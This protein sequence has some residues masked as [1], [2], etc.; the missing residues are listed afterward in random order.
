MP[1][2]E[3]EIPVDDLPAVNMQANNSAPGHGW[4][5]V[6]AK[7]LLAVFC[8]EVGG[9]L[10]VLPWHETWN[11]NLLSGTDAHWYVVWTSPYFRGAVSGIGLVNLYISLMELTHLLR[12]SKK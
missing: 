12:G 3:P 2:G 8:A 7:V 4:Y 9:F 1:L 11:Q 6:L 10:V 5:R